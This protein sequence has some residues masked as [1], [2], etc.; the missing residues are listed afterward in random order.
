[1]AFF[2]IGSRVAADDLKVGDTL[3]E[4]RIERILEIVD[5]EDEAD[6]FISAFE[7]ILMDGPVI[8]YWRVRRVHRGPPPRDGGQRLPRGWSAVRIHLPRQRRPLPPR[9]RALRAAGW[10]LPLLKS[11][12][13]QRRLP[14]GPALQRK[15]IAELMLAYDGDPAPVRSAPVMLYPTP[16]GIDCMWRY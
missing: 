8:H 16:D 3:G 5:S 1:M 12:I 4:D 15:D 7:I 14:P 11:R 9:L 6:G 2:E 10:A 13:P